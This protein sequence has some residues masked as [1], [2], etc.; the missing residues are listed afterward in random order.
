MPQVGNIDFT[1]PAN[2]PPTTKGVVANVVWTMKVT[3]DVA[4]ARDITREIDLVV[5]PV[6]GE[7]ADNAQP[8]PEAN[9]VVCQLAECE[10]NL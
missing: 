10:M 9:T 6:P 5:H 4:R 7:S 1:I 8:N 2:A 3:L